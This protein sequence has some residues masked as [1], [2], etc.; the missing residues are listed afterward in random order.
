MAIYNSMLATVSEHNF[1]QSVMTL[2]SLYSEL[3]PRSV[4]A[5]IMEEIPQRGDF[6]SKQLFS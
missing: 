6:L 1:R 4:A 2:G 5:D 3:P